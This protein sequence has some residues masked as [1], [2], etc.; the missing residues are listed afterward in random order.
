MQTSSCISEMVGE[1]KHQ[2][3]LTRTS[4]DRDRRPADSQKPEVQTQAD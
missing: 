2:S 4:R 3:Q 1:K